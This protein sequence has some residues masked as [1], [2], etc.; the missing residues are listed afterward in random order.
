L[1]YKKGGKMSEEIIENEQEEIPVKPH[2]KYVAW[3][4]S[5]GQAIAWVLTRI[6]QGIAWVVTSISNWVKSLITVRD[7]FFCAL[8]FTASSV[9]CYMLYN[10]LIMAFITLG[11]ILHNGRIFELTEIFP[12]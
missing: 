11:K 10:K 2:P 1:L 12:K 6:G 7:I 5:V 3:L 9:V 8:G 4:L